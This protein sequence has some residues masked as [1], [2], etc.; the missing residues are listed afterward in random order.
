MFSEEQRLNSNFIISSLYIS[1]E[2]KMNCI[3]RIDDKDKNLFVQKSDRKSRWN[4][5]SQ[6][7]I[8]NDLLI[9]AEKSINVTDICKNHV[10]TQLCT[11]LDTNEV[12]DIGFN[13]I[14]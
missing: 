7:V 10:K 11:L 6:I 12:V 1:E 8:E 2:G 14:L 4:L 9:C 13:N 5:Y 3:S